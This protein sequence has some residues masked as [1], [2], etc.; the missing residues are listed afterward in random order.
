MAL[1]NKE[2]SYRI[3]F[4]KDLLCTWIPLAIIATYQDNVLL[5]FVSIRLRNI[6]IQFLLDILVLSILTLTLF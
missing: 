2:I 6:Y 5:L 4:L 1:R 3:H